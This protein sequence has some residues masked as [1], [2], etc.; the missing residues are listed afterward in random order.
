M[1]TKTHWYIVSLSDYCISLCTCYILDVTVS[2]KS[3]LFILIIVSVISSLDFCTSLCSMCRKHPADVDGSSDGFLPRWPHHQLWL[4]R[5][6]RNRLGC[7]MRSG[8]KTS[9]PRP[10]TSTSGCGRVP[11]PALRTVCSAERQAADWKINPGDT[12]GASE[13]SK[14]CT[15]SWQPA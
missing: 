7:G 2:L 4:H 1:K 13:W 5:R 6:P 9:P 15:S 12:V 8:I 11:Y 14:T 10:A 3:L